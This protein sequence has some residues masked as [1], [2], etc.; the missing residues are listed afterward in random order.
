MRDSPRDYTIRLARLP[1]A[2]DGF[3]VADDLQLVV[4]AAQIDKT[5]KP[6]WGHGEGATLWRLIAWEIDIAKVSEEQ[7]LRAVRH[8]HTAR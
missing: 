4:S 1:E 8:D 6:G 5:L 2:A 3:R 7:E